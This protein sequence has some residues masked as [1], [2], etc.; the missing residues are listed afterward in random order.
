MI[1]LYLMASI[2]PEKRTSYFVLPLN[3]KT[4]FYIYKWILF[5]NVFLLKS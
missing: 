2:F 4:G 5:L 1:L 3:G